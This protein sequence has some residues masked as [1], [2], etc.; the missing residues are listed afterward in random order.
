VT[1]AAE[2]TTESAMAAA[3]PATEP[4]VP[5]ATANDVMATI[6]KAVLRTSNEQA[7][8]VAAVSPTVSAVSQ[9]IPAVSIATVPIVTVSAVAVISG[10]LTTNES[11]DR[12]DGQRC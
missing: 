2:A 5:E 4:T 3:K 8:A 10:R 1:A 9:A 11:E 7:A 12:H 6:A